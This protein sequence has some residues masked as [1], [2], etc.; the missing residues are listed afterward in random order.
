MLKP[1]RHKRVQSARPVEF[2]SLLNNRS[3]IALGAQDSGWERR[4]PT[5]APGRYVTNVHLGFDRFAGQSRSRSVDGSSKTIFTGTLNHFNKIT[6]GVFW[7]Q[8]GEPAA[9][10]NLKAFDMSVEIAAGDGINPD[11]NGL[12][13]FHPLQLGLF[14]VGNDSD[15][16]RDK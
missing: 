14:E 3:G 15:V 10:A 5:T 9:G 13:N 7:R 1:V 16:G 8:Q 4:C 11:G 12:T 2:H 6:S